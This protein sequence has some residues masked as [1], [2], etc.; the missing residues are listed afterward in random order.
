MDR[1]K[2]PYTL[3]A[4]ARSKA[5]LIIDIA[6]FRMTMGNLYTQYKRENPELNCA[7]S[8]DHGF[9]CT[10]FQLDNPATPKEVK[11]FL[12]KRESERRTKRR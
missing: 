12:G 7:D 6:S 1:L 4:M 3:R 2:I 8:M 9:Y 11:A 10:D 5:S